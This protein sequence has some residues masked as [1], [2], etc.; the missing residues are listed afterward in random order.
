[1]NSISPEV[2][3]AE[4]DSAD[5]GSSPASSA[6]SPFLPSTNIQFADVKSVNLFV[7]ATTNDRFWKRVHIL[8]NGCWHCHLAPNAKGYIPFSPG[9]RTGGKKR[10][11]R[12]LFKILFGK[13]ADNVLVLHSCDDRACINPN[14]L[15]AGS[16]AKNTADMMNKGRGANQSWNNYN[17]RDGNAR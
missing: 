5:A 13:I 8:E 15:S 2:K 6:M 14:H 12:V 4:F 3:T 7:R 10:L 16:A 9:G 11:H 17:W 1:M